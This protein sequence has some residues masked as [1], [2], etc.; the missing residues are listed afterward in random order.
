MGS[1]SGG[2]TVMAVKTV[3]AIWE[4]RNHRCRL[5]YLP[6]KECRSEHVMGRWLASAHVAIIVA[7]MWEMGAENAAFP[8]RTEL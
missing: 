5:R 1:E 3:A 2:G 7:A 4:I 6:L 8:L